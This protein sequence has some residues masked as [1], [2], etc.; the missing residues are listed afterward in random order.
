MNKAALLASVL[1]ALAPFPALAEPVLLISI[2]GLRPG[3]VLEA[4]KR[5]LALP[6]LRRFLTDGAHASG[7]TGVLPTLTYPSHTTL[8]TGVSPAR[9]GIVSNNSFDPMQ[10]N[11][12]GWYW[13][14][15]DVKVPMLW[16]AAAK[17][18]LSTGNV[19]WPVS[20]AAKGISWNLPQIWRTG[21]ADDA[22]LLDALATPGLK[23]EL[24][25][26]VGQPYAMGIDESLSGDQNRG[27]F[28]TA[29]IAAH[30][31]DFLTVYLTALDHEQHGSGPDTPGAK[32]VLEKID[33]IVGDLVA[34]E[35]KAHPD[36]LI[37]LVSDHGFEATHSG[38]NLFRPF[39]DAGLVTLGADGKVASWQAM[40]WIGGGSAAI[41]LARPDDQALADKVKALI[42]KLAA[43][44]TNGIDRIVG[45]AEMAKLGGNP[46]A[47]FTINL[48][49]GFVTDIFRGANAPLVAPTPVKGMHGYFPGPANLRATFMAMGPGVTPGKD[50]GLID[51]RA[52]APTLA[53]AMG[54]KLPDAEA[55]PIDLR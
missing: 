7:V 51:M 11:Q 46:Q 32:A 19:H 35:R 22:Q 44:P 41:M 40:P 26:A 52:I 6:N 55:A 3:D 8:M 48:K 17:A 53:R 16:D 42:D 5:G 30:Q 31:P 33:A 13:Y 45:R 20:V 39:I 29:L 24:E 21:H 28:A 2:D 36:A 14:A 15:Q 34:A 9:H 12:G 10:I 43:N 25:R 49:P 18:G 50:L 47:S 27:R 1:L 37:A 23:A 38:L 54:A 4:D